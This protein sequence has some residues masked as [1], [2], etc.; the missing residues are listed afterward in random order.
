MRLLIG[1]LALVDFGLPF[2]TWNVEGEEAWS[3]VTE[4][5]DEDMLFQRALLRF[6]L[7]CFA[8]TV[9][10]PEPMVEPASG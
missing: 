8:L 9:D 5:E 1:L 3:M 2:G 4:E 10:C 7:A 6:L